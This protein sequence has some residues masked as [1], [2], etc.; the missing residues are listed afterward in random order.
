[1]AAVAAFGVGLEQEPFFPDESA[2]VAQGYFF[3][4]YASGRRDDWAWL[5]YHAY[6]L[7]PLPK[8]LI[9]AA[10]RVAGERPPG[11]IEA[12]RWF[13]NVNKRFVNDR[14][15]Y[16][17][18]WPSVFLGALGCVAL[19]AVGTMA[20]DARVGLLAAGLLMVDPLY[21]MHARR[22][23]ADAP[24][25]AM[26]LCT[27]AVGLW[28]WRR[29]LEGRM[30]LAA[31]FFSSIG[32]GV[33]AG[34]AVLAKLNGGLAL[35]IV[36]AWALLALVLGR[37]PLRRRLAIV[38]M[39]GMAGIAATATFVPLNPFVTARPTGR[40]PVEFLGP[41]PARLN[42]LRRLDWRIRGQSPPEAATPVEEGPIGRLGWLIQHRAEVSIKAQSDF[43]HN[44]LTRPADKATT[45]AVQGFG[46]FGP[47]GPR[48]HDSLKPYPRYAWGRDWSALIWIPWVLAGVG[49]AAA[50]GR[51]QYGLGQA[52]TAWAVLLQAGM[53]LVTV[54]AFIPLAWDRYM[55]SIQAGS[56]LLASGAAVAAIDR[57]FR[58]STAPHA[59]PD[60]P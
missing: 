50:R 41:A 15:L 44:A 24:A 13:V 1:L 35:M 3:D 14:A 6:D 43:S 40:P 8:Y 19:F 2:Y 51:R 11:R 52:P 53:A 12:G 36:A 28:A 7:P 59:R 31:G 18:R 29:T 23:M 47:L 54:T 33:F 55:L 48:D 21:R 4:L 34:L 45:V 10:L 39:A 49:W 22:A 56:A 58:R 25:E 57:V 16:V 5:E 42:T 32:L 17:A 38:A 27:S 37:F 26:I 20:R 46:R 9:G 60:A 30:G